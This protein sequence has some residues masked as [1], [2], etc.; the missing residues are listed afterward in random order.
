MLKIATASAMPNASTAVTARL[1]PP[2]CA[3]VRP[4]AD[5][6]REVVNPHHAVEEDDDGDVLNVSWL[7]KTWSAIAVETVWYLTDGGSSGARAQP[8]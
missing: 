5:I 7:P 8:S 6:R 3:N 4:P 1:T 2:S